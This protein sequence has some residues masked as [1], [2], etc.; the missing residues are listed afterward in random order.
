VNGRLIQFT[1]LAAAL[2]ALAW[3]AA[4]VTLT[5]P[6]VHGIIAARLPGA[7]GAAQWMAQRYLAVGAAGAVLYLLW[8]WSL[9]YYDY[10]RPPQPQRIPLSNLGAPAV[11]LLLGFFACSQYEQMFEGA[12]LISRRVMFQAVLIVYVATTVAHYAL[13]SLL[14]RLRRDA[15]E[16]AI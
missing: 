15:G 2:L 12:P 13:S 6:L 5:P 3:D 10:R 11:L 14:L 9:R 8:A 4:V 16:D 7:A 1:G